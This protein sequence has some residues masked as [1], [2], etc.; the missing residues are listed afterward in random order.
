MR[1]AN[2]RPYPVRAEQQSTARI[3]ATRASRSQRGG[4]E[5]RPEIHTSSA[6]PASHDFPVPLGNASRGQQPRATGPLPLPSRRL[7]DRTAPRRPSVTSA[8]I[9]TAPAVTIHH[10]FAAR[11]R[12]SGFTRTPDYGRPRREQQ[13]APDS[14]GEARGGG[15]GSRPVPS[16]SRIS[17][18]QSAIARSDDSSRLSVS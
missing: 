16:A 15:L 2:G 17:E 13:Y 4:A 8:A 11:L 6:F 3:E 5:V 18:I 10:C 12:R 9:A 1:E 7:A 14:G